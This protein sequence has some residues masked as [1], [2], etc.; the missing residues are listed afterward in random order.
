MT[1]GEKSGR[2]RVTELRD[3]VDAGYWT[4]GATELDAESV[5]ASIASDLDTLTAAR[6]AAEEL[7]DVL[8]DCPTALLSSGK[9]DAL[10]N[11]LTKGTP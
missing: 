2:E 6:D 8:A 7:R 5:A 11:I 4:N 1:T 3:I 9:L 10:L